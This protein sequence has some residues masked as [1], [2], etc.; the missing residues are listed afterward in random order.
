[1]DNLVQTKIINRFHGNNISLDNEFKNSPATEGNLAK[2]IWET[3]AGNIR[4]GTLTHVTVSQ[5]PG[6]AATYSA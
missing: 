2:C 6:T 3:L 4:Q 1:L 5:T